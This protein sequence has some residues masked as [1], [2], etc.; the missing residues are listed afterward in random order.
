MIPLL[1]FVDYVIHLYEYVVIANVIF[2]WLV[3]FNVV[4]AYNP[5]VR[6]I[7]QAVGAL[8]DPILKYIRRIMPNLGGLDLSP[9]IL[10]LFCYF[11]RFVVIQGW[12]IDGIFRKQ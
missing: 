9:V 12:L 7:L 1:Q 6:S 11:L 3:A 10:L 2:S 5:F 4:N 8:T